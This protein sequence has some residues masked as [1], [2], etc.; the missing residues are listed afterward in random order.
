MKNE[1]MHRSTEQQAIKIHK[2]LMPISSNEQA[3]GL[4]KWAYG[5]HN[6][7][8]HEPCPAALNKPWDRLLE[9]Y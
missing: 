1:H 5:T 9:K 8:G 6:G 2:G 7:A 3:T 4:R